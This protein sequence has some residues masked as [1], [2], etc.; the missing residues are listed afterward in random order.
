MWSEIDQRS[1][2]A[3]VSIAIS[4]RD[5]FDLVHPYHNSCNIIDSKMI[6]LIWTVEQFAAWY[7]E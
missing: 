3:G 5:T 1:R 2:R 7:D 4:E 6:P